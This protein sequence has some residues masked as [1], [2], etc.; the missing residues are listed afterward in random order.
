[1]QTH[2]AGHDACKCPSK[3]GR[4]IR[5]PPLSSAAARHLPCMS[6]PDEDRVANET[7]AEQ[8]GPVWYE[9]RVR[10]LLGKTLLGAF[11]GMRARAHEKDTVLC[12]PVA[13]QAALHG[14]LAEIEALGLELLELRR[15]RD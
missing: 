5:Q 9:I 11:P 4:S 3:A 14:V 12:G 6:F 1:M 15:T 13:D 8:T 2:L 10:G 7:M